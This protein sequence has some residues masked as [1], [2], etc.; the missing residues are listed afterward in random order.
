MSKTSVPQEPLLVIDNGIGHT[1]STVQFAGKLR[2]QA[3][4]SMVKDSKTNPDASRKTFTNGNGEA[5]AYPFFNIF[6]VVLLPW[7]C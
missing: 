6:I 1:S 7:Q 4:P 5:F 3:A 2:Q